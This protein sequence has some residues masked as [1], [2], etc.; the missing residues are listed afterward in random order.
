MGRRTAA[1]IVAGGAGLRMGPS[2]VRKQ[3]LELLGQ[4]VLV[5][6]VLPFIEHPGIG[7]VVV[8]LPA[9]DLV[10]PPLWLDN[11]GAELVPGGAERSDSVRNGLAALPDSTETVLIHDGARPFVTLGLIDRVLSAAAEGPV[12]PGLRATDTLKQVDEHGV[13][14]A[15]LE[16]SGIWHAQ[17]PQGFPYA[18]MRAAHLRSEQEG[19]HVTDDASI[20]ERAG[21]SVRIVQGEPQNIKITRPLDLDVAAALAYRQRT[22]QT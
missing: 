17:T 13:V 1:V 2:T 19:W 22:S 6:A 12:V 7:R 4:P 18:A 15:T 16:R 10:D 21:M 9:D 3:Y 14:V 5:W 11:L 20:C 8:V